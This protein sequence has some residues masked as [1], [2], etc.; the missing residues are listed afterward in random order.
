M[1]IEKRPVDGLIRFARNAGT[2]SDVHT[3]R[4]AT[5]NRIAPGVTRPKRL[6]RHKV[7]NSS[8]LLTGWLTRAQVAGEI[9]VSVDT[10]ARWETRRIGPPCVRMGRKVLYRAD[11][12]SEWLVSRE[13][14]ALPSK[15]ARP[16][17]ER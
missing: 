12:F 16:D 8:P 6:I 14:G 9:G 1:Q 11:A 5:S 10:L 3:S 15:G 13:R 4:Q 2:W 17:S 7:R